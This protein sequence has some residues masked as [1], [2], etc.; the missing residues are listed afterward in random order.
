MG[1]GPRVPPQAELGYGGRF[2]PSITPSAARE[3]DITASRAARLAD[4]IL[5]FPPSRARPRGLPEGSIHHAGKDEGCAG[6]AATL[7]QLEAG[8]G[9]RAPEKGIGTSRGGALWVRFS[10][11]GKGRSRC[12]GADEGQKP[13]TALAWGTD[14]LLGS[15]SLG[16]WPRPPALGGSLESGSMFLPQPREGVLGAG[17]SGVTWGPGRAGR[18]GR[19]EG[20]PYF[21]SPRR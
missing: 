9:G 10:T 14:R 17:A 7:R 2:S 19:P 20:R 4:L 13:A 6:V 11:W 1:Q 3:A 5:S 15:G 18:G 12:P 21:I 16:A 8:G